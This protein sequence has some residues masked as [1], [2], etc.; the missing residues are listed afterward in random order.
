MQVIMKV[1]KATTM[2]AS[3]YLLLPA[4]LPAN[5]RANLPLDLPLAQ[6]YHFKPHKPSSDN[7]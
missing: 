7:S 6:L 1:M 3:V 2:T 5:L 4:N